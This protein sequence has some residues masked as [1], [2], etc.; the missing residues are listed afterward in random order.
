MKP[1]PTDIYDTDLTDTLAATLQKLEDAADLVNATSYDLWTH[2]KVLSRDY[3]EMGV[4][5]AA[6]LRL[7]ARAAG[8]ELRIRMEEG[9]LRIDDAEKVAYV[10]PFLHGLDRVKVNS[11][12]MCKDMVE[13]GVDC[14]KSARKFDELVDR[15][16][17][18]ISKVY[19]KL[20]GR[21]YGSEEMEVEY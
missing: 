13:S 16:I 15:F 18:N 20:N 7:H 14:W 21:E 11:A 9:E 4:E 2:R 1:N 17:L 19:L 8:C 6:N 12:R 3:D 5:N 10:F